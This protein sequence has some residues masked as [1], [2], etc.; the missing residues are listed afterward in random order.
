[1]ITGFD[2]FSPV[3]PAVLRL[4]KTH[5]FSFVCRYYGSPGSKKLL[6]P[7]EVKLVSEAGLHIFSVFERV[8]GRPFQGAPAGTEDGK[9]AHIQAIYAGQPEGSTIAFAVDTDVDM[10]KAVNRNFIN[11]YFGSAKAALDGKFQVGG[12]GG[13]DVL[14]YLLNANLISVAWLAGAMG[15]GG[16]HRFDS[17]LRWHLKQ[18]PTIKGGDLGIEYDTNVA[19]A[20]DRI[21]AWVPIP[22]VP[23]SNVEIDLF[24]LQRRL[25]AGGFYKGTIDGVPLGATAKALA[26][27]YHA[28]H[29]GA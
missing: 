10:T 4:A 20:L 7:A 22:E 18:G 5:G 3:T 14:D 11:S 13:G 29:A 21:G 16:S 15:W 6:L 26:D 27:Y 1:M 8:P 23:P 19:L 2:C 24:D 9:L 12:Y 28:R 17:G 25:A